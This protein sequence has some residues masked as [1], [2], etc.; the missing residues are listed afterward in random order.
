[1]CCRA[2]RHMYPVLIRHSSAVLSPL[3]VNIFMLWIKSAHAA[4]QGIDRVE[5][6]NPAAAHPRQHMLLGFL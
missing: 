6:S 3:I 4:E 1:M 2:D 5:G